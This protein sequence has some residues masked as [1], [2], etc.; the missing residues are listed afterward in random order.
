MSSSDERLI[1]YGTLAPG[2]PN[3]H[4]LSDLKGTWTEG[5]VRGQ[6][7]QVGWGA[8]QGF[9][10][11]RASRE[12]PRVRAFLFESADLPEH[13]ARLDAFEGEEYQ[14]VLVPFENESDEPLPGYLY[15]GPDPDLKP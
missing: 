4:H 1:V 8:A 7:Y 5:F 15:E 2:E 13:W 3:H 12:G 6:L 14:R 9:P 10:A 11:L